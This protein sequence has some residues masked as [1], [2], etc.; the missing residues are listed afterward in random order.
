MYLLLLVGAFSALSGCTSLPSVNPFVDATA[1]M[2][3][4]VVSAGSATE[5]ELQQMEGGEEF[6]KNF[7]KQWESRVQAMNAMADYADSLQAIVAA[8]QQSENT[9]NALADNVTRLAK[10]AGIAM[11]AAGS[12]T[13]A[14]DTAK[15]VYQQ[16]ALM[17]ASHSLEK[18]LASSQAAIEQIAVKMALDLKDA[19]DIFKAAN[20]DIIHQIKEKNNV[21]LGFRKELLSERDKIYGRGYFH[22]TEEDK[23]RLSEFDHMVEETNNW[24]VP[25]QENLGK[26]EKRLAAGEALFNAAQDAVAQWGLAHYKL[27]LAIRERRPVSVESLTLAATEVRSLV[28]RMRAL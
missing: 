19:K 1:E 25:M 17:R 9:V 11:P 22:L 26:V 4:A 23:R 8:G 2:R 12:L 28:K 5:L 6:T 18:A 13:L 10:A 7:Q 27:V 20:A 21:G 24:Y 15:F 3:S 14:T 16:I